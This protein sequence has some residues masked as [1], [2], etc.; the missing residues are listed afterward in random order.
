MTQTTFSNVSNAVRG[1]RQH[2]PELAEGRDGDTIRAMYLNGSSIDLE[3]VAAVQAERMGAVAG[4]TLLGVPV[5]RRSVGGCATTR[6]RRVYDTLPGG[7]P[8]AAA[9]AAAV[10]SGIAYYTAR[11]QYQRWSKAA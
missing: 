6:A 7:T 10:E 4:S 2:F 3:A 11:T 1:F 5:L 8:R 9:I